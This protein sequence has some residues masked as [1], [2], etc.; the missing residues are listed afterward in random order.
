M[1]FEIVR[2][3]VFSL[4]FFGIGYIVGWMRN[5]WQIKV[6]FPDLYDEMKRRCE[7]A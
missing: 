7:D 1:M 6:A 2:L 4:C 5:L 3:I